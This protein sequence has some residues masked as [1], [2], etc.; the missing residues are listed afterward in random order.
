MFSNITIA[1]ADCTSFQDV[2]TEHNVEGG[3][4]YLKL[5]VCITGDDETYLHN[6]DDT[7]KKKFLTFNDLMVFLKNNYGDDFTFELLKVNIEGFEYP[8]FAHIFK[9]PDF[10]L[11]NTATIHL[12]VHRQG[13]QLIG[14]SWNSL[15]FAE[16]L[17]AH[18]FSG[19]YIPYAVEK[20]HD[21]TATTDIA[22]VNQSWYIDSET[23]MA[24]EIWAKLDA[25]NETKEHE[26][27]E[28]IP[29]YCQMDKVLQNEQINMLIEDAES[30]G[31][32]L[33]AD[34][35]D[36]IPEWTLHAYYC[37]ENEECGWN[38]AISEST[39]ARVYD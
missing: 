25:P 30:I 36:G 37:V 20:W 21:S 14:L 17:V 38:G 27:T 23:F 11:E 4:L 12:E 39:R 3:T 34:A 13:M 33:R 6:I 9:N 8:M 28:Q 31:W 16:L 24:N 32:D 1:I 22:F 18:F 7:L 15:I 19:G 2:S 29:R 10:L 35:V 5:P 26:T